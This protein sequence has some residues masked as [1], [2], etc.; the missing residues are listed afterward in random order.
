MENFKNYLEKKNIEEIT[1]FLRNSPVDLLKTIGK[2]YRL[3]V[4]TKK[5]ELIVQEIVR[6]VESDVQ[7]TQPPPIHVMTISQLR[8]KARELNI[9]YSKIS[10]KQD[11]RLAVIK[12]MKQTQQMEN[13]RVPSAT[14]SS[15]EPTSMI[16]TEDGLTN[17]LLQS[18]TLPYLKALAKK[19]KIKVSKLSKNQL[20]TLILEAQ[21]TGEPSRTLDTGTEK[22]LSK[23]AKNELI[24]LAQGMGID[25]KGKKKTDIIRMIKNARNGDSVVEEMETTM[26][27][28][29][30]ESVPIE[31]AV[32]KVMLANKKITVSDVKKL[33]GKFDITI[34][35][36]MTKRVDLI[37]LLTLT[38]NSTSPS[39]VVIVESQPPSSVLI[40][41]TT[42]AQK[43][44]TGSQKSR[45][46]AEVIP[47]SM[48]ERPPTQ[49]SKRR[50]TPMA[51]DIVS[52]DDIQSPFS[53]VR[54]G[55]L[56]EEPTEK[57][58]Q[59]E[60]YRCLEFYEYPK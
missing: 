28:P 37:H 53:P 9:D 26:T 45:K 51:S 48:I 15:I 54:V 60:L 31:K 1:I 59:E 32:E 29:E 8:N 47:Q 25:Y 7:F 55:D 56:L 22:D 14:S 23:L 52:L 57:Q 44:K 6:A 38:K 17:D 13:G 40:P 4:S 46:Q 2:R 3:P 19:Y 35:K 11:L 34:P 30:I 42:P 49:T 50:K 27:I 21:V 36:G 20:I 39:S 58:L 16:G 41:T 10:L 5:K 33:L 18:K 24:V 43:T 12:K